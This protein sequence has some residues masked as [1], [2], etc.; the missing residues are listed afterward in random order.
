MGLLV[1]TFFLLKKL[2]SNLFSNFVI[3]TKS[4]CQM[5]VHL[6]YYQL[7]YYS[8]KENQYML[9]ILYW[10]CLLPN[11]VATFLNIKSYVSRIIVQYHPQLRCLYY[12]AYH[13]F[14]VIK[15]D[16]RHIINIRSQEYKVYVGH[17]HGCSCRNRA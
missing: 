10:R 3:C 13:G 2:K 9:N 1:C 7:H 15:C 16:L 4:L 6:K 8:V 11:N 12:N 5:G 14:H 17:G